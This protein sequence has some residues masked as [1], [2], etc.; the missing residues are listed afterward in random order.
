MCIRT[1]FTHWG[2]SDLQWIHSYSLCP[3]DFEFYGWS[4]GVSINS[5]SYVRDAYWWKCDFSTSYNMQC[6]IG[7][8]FFHHK[9]VTKT[10]ALIKFT[11]KWLTT[12]FQD[13]MA[14]MSQRQK[15]TKWVK[16]KNWALLYKCYTDLLGS[17][18]AYYFGILLA[19]MVSIYHAS[20]FLVLYDCYQINTKYTYKRVRIHFI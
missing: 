3:L 2:S 12:E 19:L 14:K 13:R 5:R 16:D 18:A 20:V 7:C 11:S 8:N 10:S 6:I 17:S 1:Q 15:L 9:I 4:R